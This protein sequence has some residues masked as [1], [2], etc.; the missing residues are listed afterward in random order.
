MTAPRARWSLAVVAWLVTAPAAAQELPAGLAAANER[1]VAAWNGDDPSAVA[2]LYAGDAHAIAYGN[3]YRGLD[4][5][6]RN[7]LP[8]VLIIKDLRF[9]DESFRRVAGGWR[10]DG[11]FAL[12]VFPADEA[13]WEQT[14]RYTLTWARDAGGEWRVHWTH[15]VPDARPGG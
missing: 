1:Y 2:R 9:M 10:V 14:G 6:Q 11:R 12:T 8:G 3:H 4:D 7:W 5:I 15:V 13:P